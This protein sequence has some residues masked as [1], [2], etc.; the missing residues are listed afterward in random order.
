MKYIF[1]LYNF[2]YNKG[3]LLPRSAE[4]QTQVEI[5]KH[6]T[7]DKQTTLIQDIEESFISEHTTTTITS[8][9]YREMKFLNSQ[10]K[11]KNGRLHKSLVEKG[12]DNSPQI[13]I[14]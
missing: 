10:K 14:F 13:L 4:D 7:T 9:T 11:K 8:N 2:R 6:T 1:L 3:V 5:D 12:I